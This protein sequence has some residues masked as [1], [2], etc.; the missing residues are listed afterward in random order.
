M[1]KNTLN[2]QNRHI[3]R[4]IS[5]GSAETRTLYRD[6]LRDRILVSHLFYRTLSRHQDTHFVELSKHSERAVG[7]HH[8]VWRHLRES[9]CKGKKI[10]MSKYHKKNQ[11]ADTIVFLK[12]GVLCLFYLHIKQMRQMLS[13]SLPHAVPGVGDK[14]HRDLVL[15]IAVH[16]VPK[17]LLGCR[18][19]C[20]APHQHPIDVKEKPEGVGGLRRE[21]GHR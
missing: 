16:Q 5:R 18:D 4:S 9:E 11:P 6:G 1:N 3:L 10:Q 17:A 21:L 15:P 7:K 14:H 12:K 13:F 8:L 20:P 2:K 19:G